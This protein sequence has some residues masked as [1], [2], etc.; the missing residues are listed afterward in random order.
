M[1]GIVSVFSPAGGVDKNKLLPAMGALAHRG[2]D[3]EGVWFSKNK[4]VGL[5]HRRLSI[6]DPKQGAQPMVSCDGK[7]AAIVNGEFYDYKKIKL[8]LRKKGYLFQT[9][10]DSEII[11]YLY[12][13]YGLDFVHH[14]RGEFA[15][16]LYDEE[17]NKL[18]AVRD[19]FG[20][21]PL[22]YHLD[23]HGSI[24]I[25]SEAKAIFALGVRPQW[26]HYSLY[27]SFCLQYF[28]QDQTLFKGVYQLKPGHIL[29]YDGAR[30]Q[31]KKYWDLDFPKAR[32]KNLQKQSE[33]EIINKLEKILKDSVSVR[34]QN[35][36]ARYCCQLSGGVDSSTVA[37]LV[38]VLG[39]QK[40]NC[41]TLSFPH[42]SY[43][44]VEI[45]RKVAGHIGAEFTPV[46]ADAHQIIDVISDATYYS[47]GLY[48]NNHL[49]AKYI[50]HRAMKKAGYKIVLTGEGADECFAGY[51]HLLVDL[52]GK[53]PEELQ[54]SENVVGGVHFLSG[55]E[56][57]DLRIV[58]KGLGYVPAFLEAKAA[59]G[60]SLHNLLNPSFKAEY[61]SS[62][63]MTDFMNSL[64]IKN[65][66]ADRE[67]I[68]QSSYIWIKFTL[69]NYILKTLGDGTEMPNSIEGRLPF[70]DHNLFEF[71][72]TI[73]TSLKIKNGLQKYVL[74]KVAERLLPKEIA[75]R[76]KQTFMA[77]P[78]SL[79][80][81]K[82][83]LTFITDNF[84]SRSFKDMNLFDQK[85]IMQLITRVSKM[86]TQKQIAFEP[87]IM[88]ALSSFLIHQRF[89]LASL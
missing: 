17:K 58:K 61:T 12:K 56:T 69:A 22:Q 66:L 3:G 34:L 11:L 16:V 26:D 71:V 74:R 53:L 19:R 47:E 83:G 30:L 52:L 28:P 33:K 42:E 40:L 86:N 78:F 77:P 67:R 4:N 51:I 70:L 55:G 43:N 20:I 85:K 59:I 18:I 24:Y 54:K 6:I 31:I 80:N 13:E 36:G 25:A 88:L 44:E 38:S 60:Y 72:R 57:L 41:F 10:S 29:I 84:E 2:P 39:D 48:I 64:D 63:I 82:R 62:K 9:Q 1:C 68:D 79:L 46:I 50:L 76:P 15:L 49:A 73:P 87:V 89:N 75:E 5:G 21:K 14:L 81:D 27:H 37:A 8:D 23:V 7:I 45:A 65:Q 35:D 32:N